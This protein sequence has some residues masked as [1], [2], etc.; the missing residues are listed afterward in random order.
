MKKIMQN[1]S[2]LAFLIVAFIVLISD[3]NKPES[4]SYWNIVSPQKGVTVDSPFSLVADFVDSY[5][6][7]HEYWGCNYVD[8]SVISSAAS[9]TIGEYSV[10][11]MVDSNNRLTIPL[12]Y[13]VLGVT[14]Q[15]Y[16]EK[17]SIVVNVTDVNEE[18]KFNFRK[19]VTP[20][21]EK[22]ETCPELEKI[23]YEECEHQDD[24]EPFLPDDDHSVDNEVDSDI[25]D[26]DIDT[27]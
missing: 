16:G 18:I 14:D 11:L 4:D 2:M 24:D 8:V 5:P 15:P 26:S 23:T 9:K 1:L 17:I 7:T 10:K 27:F 13:C 22:V 19:G 25:N 20:S 12:S 3:S 6:R 21:S